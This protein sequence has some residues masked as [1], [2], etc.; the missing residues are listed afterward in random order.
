MELQLFPIRIDH[1][2]D[3]IVVLRSTVQTECQ[4]MRIVRQIDRWADAVP[5]DV[6]PPEPAPAQRGMIFPE[7]NQRAGSED[8]PQNLR[9]TAYKAV[10]RSVTPCRRNEDRHSRQCWIRVGV[11]EHGRSGLRL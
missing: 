1:H 5:G 6:L 10:Q 7:R 11:C 3:V 9:R 8:L 4:A 2:V